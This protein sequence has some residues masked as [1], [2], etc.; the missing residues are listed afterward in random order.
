MGLTASTGT[1][2]Q[3]GAI[4]CIQRGSVMNFKPKCYGHQLNTIIVSSFKRGNINKAY[5]ST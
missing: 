2:P 1:T 3:L 4:S 5:C